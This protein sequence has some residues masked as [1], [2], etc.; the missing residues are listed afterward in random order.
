MQSRSDADN[1]G[2]EF[3]LFNEDEIENSQ[4]ELRKN[5]SWKILVVDDDEDVHVLT[6]LVLRG[7]EFGGEKVTLISAFSGQETRKVLTENPDI[8]IILL[9]VIME[10]EYTGLEL[11]KYIREELKNRKVRIILR[12]G[13]PG[14]ALERKVVS[15]YE[16]DDYKTKTELTS[17]K[18]FTSI[19]TALRAYR[20]ITSIERIQAGLLKIL[21]YMPA[22]FS[23]QSF[24]QLA[25]N[26][27]QFLNVILISDSAHE[28]SSSFSS[29]LAA[30]DNNTLRI[31]AATEEFKN[32]TGRPVQDIVSDTIT[33]ELKKLLELRTDVVQDEFF[34]KF[35]QLDE[36]HD[37]IV[38][39]KSN[40]KFSMEENELVSIFMDNAKIALN[41]YYQLALSR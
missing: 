6:R 37:C 41:H 13:Q 1:T 7:Y 38:Y 16:I 30:T 23:A 29:F 21:N 24:R 10:D 40:Y 17:D 27:L 26:I 12:T 4:K 33:G 25:E 8:A 35:L 34:I 31:I 5:R 18:L 9:D 32:V 2:E 15:A 11:V 36:H 14:G 22:L 39:L 20:D 28:F 19:T 3:L